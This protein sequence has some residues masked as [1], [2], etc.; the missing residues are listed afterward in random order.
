M[1]AIQEQMEQLSDQLRNEFVEDGIEALDRLDSLVDDAIRGEGDPAEALQE[2]RKLFHMLKG[3]G[4]THDYPEVSIIA[5]RAEEYLTGLPALKE[6]QRGDLQAYF[7][8]LKRA[9]SGDIQRP[10][11]FKAEIRQLPTR[12]S[13]N[14]GDVDIREVEVLLVSAAKV[15]AHK[16]RNELEACGY[17][18]V[19]ISSPITAL[20]LAIRTQ[21]DL[22]ISSTVLDT[23]TGVDL[24]RALGSISATEQIP[25]ALLTSFQRGHPEL[26]GIPVD[27]GII[28]VGANF[29]DDVA[30]VMSRFEIG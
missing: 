15:V 11:A 28:R 17:R 8:A 10:A 6:A 24:A 3:S 25:F 12:W 5:M 4:S 2:A 13:F 19:T 26:A 22:I 20:E 29:A 18:V 14:V 27:A 1:N 7:E 30:D 23:M 16:V 9:L 21:P